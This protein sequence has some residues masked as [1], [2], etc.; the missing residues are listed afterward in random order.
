MTGNQINASFWNRMTVV[1]LDTTWFSILKCLDHFNNAVCCL[2]LYIVE[3]QDGQEQL[4]P[5]E[6]MGKGYELC[7]LL[8]RHFLQELRKKHD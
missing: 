8:S 3:L 1:Q 5:K 7:N 6:A 4:I 2:G